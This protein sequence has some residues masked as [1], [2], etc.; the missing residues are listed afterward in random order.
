[1]SFVL[2]SLFCNNC[3]YKKNIFKKTRFQAVESELQGA[4]LNINTITLGKPVLY[5]FFFLASMSFQVFF[6]G[7]YLVLGEKIGKLIV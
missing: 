2:P 5:V 4:S 1:M 3:T 7:Y 6:L